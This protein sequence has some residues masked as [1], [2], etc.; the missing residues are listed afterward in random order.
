MPRFSQRKEQETKILKVPT[1]SFCKC[2]PEKNPCSVGSM[3][4]GAIECPAAAQREILGR[5]PMSD[6]Q[7]V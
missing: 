4:A 6:Q 3:S 2:L 5:E 7:E 1:I